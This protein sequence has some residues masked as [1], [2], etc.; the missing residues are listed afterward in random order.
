MRYPVVTM[1]P[2]DAARDRLVFA[3]DVADEDR[4]RALVTELRDSVGT[5]K[6]GL[7]LLLRG[8]ME[9][10]RRITDGSALF[11]DAKL[12]D[13]PATVERATA[14]IVGAGLPVRFITVHE[15]VS[16]AVRGAA[17]R[18]GIL[19]V[20]VLTS[21]PAD[22][23]GEAALTETVVARAVEAQ[24]D[25][26]A[27]IVCSPR[28]LRAVRAVLPSFPCVTPGVRPAWASVDGDDQRRTATASEAIRDGASCI[29]V[30]RPI[31][32]ARVPRD[33]ARRVLEEIAEAAGASPSAR[34]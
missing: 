10:A 5:F 17:G 19:R 24:R 33:A 31:R 3:L 16:A 25:G 23:R 6:V 2:L 8:G 22:A 28:E 1:S 20:T 21:Q 13:V 11:I 18:A 12:H 27:G 14:Q 15:P 4:A 32:D 7:E 34:A 26:A 9:L 30:G 29:V